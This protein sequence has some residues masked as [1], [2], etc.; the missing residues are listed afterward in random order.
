MPFQFVGQ[1][2]QLSVQRYNTWDGPITIYILKF[3]NQILIILAII[4][5]PND[6]AVTKMFNWVAD[7]P[8]EHSCSL[9]GITPP[10]VAIT[11]GQLMQ[12]SDKEM[13]PTNP[14][15]LKRS[16]GLETAISPI[17]PIHPPVLTVKRLD[18]DQ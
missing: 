4:V 10:V 5:I 7:Q 14:P 15:V 3:T 16:G 12:L 11:T 1:H 6:E 13:F 8:F 17:I 18:S 2:I 9:M